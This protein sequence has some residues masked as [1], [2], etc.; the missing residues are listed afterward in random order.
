MELY[1]LTKKLKMLL[2][3]KKLKKSKKFYNIE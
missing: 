1:R 3:E 2:L